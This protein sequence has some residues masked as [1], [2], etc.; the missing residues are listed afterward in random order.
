[1]A[2]RQGIERAAAVGIQALDAESSGKLGDA[3]ELFQQAAKDLLECAKRER[4]GNR[5]LT[6]Q[7]QV[8]EL[9]DSAERVKTKIRRQ[10]AETAARVVHLSSPKQPVAFPTAFYTTRASVTAPLPRSAPLASP[11][12]PALPARPQST[13]AITPQLV[14]AANTVATEL[15]KE[16]NSGLR[17]VITSAGTALLQ[18]VS[19]LI[20]FDK[21]HQVHQKVGAGIAAGVTKA[22]EI[23]AQYDVRGK[24]VAMG[25]KAQEIERDHNVSGKVADVLTAAGK[26]I[27][28]AAASAQDA[29]EKYQI[30]QRVG[31]GMK[32]GLAQAREFNAEY[33]VTDRIAA[34][35]TT[36]FERARELN[37][38]HQIT[39]K[40]GQLALQG[41]DSIASAA[42]TV[43]ARLDDKSSAP[44]A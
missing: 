21:E 23:D 9:L 15:A 17:G 28:T 30:Q 43:S 1:M 19:R 37:Q 31:E 25:Q 27:S 7:R 2:M 18:G 3:F 32:R 12:A 10:D 8:S 5:K 4:D 34:G 11:T 41:L 26:A 13:S 20:A 22:Q 42:R 6:L 35:A 29:N 39:Q 38:E 16:E 24:V 14:Q 33:N 44:R 40:M 36:A